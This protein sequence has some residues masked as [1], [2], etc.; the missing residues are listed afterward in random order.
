MQSAKEMDKDNIV[1]ELIE[2][3]GITPLQAKK[4]LGVT[5]NFAKDKLPLMHV[6]IDNFLNQEIKKFEFKKYID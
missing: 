6:L 3:L 4:A 1:S 2:N 5:A